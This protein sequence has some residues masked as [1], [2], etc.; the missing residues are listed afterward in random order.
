MRRKFVRALA[1]ALAAAP[2]ATLP[3]P[4]AAQSAEPIRIGFLTVRT[5]PLAAGGKQM[6][7]GI[8]LFLKE[9]NNTIAGRKVELVIADTGGNPAGARTKTQDLVERNKVHVIIG[10]LAAFEAIA[11]DDYIRQTK[12]PVVSCSAA[13]EDPTPR[14]ASPWFARRA[15]SP[16]PR[17]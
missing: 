11:I 7:E 4:V 9:R 8:L 2:L 3:L 14:Q 5:G 6:E 17:N 12:T 10:P 1:A 15:A 16:P 13:G